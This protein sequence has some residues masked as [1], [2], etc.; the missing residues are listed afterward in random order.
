M[1]GRLKCA[2]TEE[3]R[4]VLSQEMRN[5]WRDNPEFRQRMSEESSAR[6]KEERWKD[7]TF[8]E[9]MAGVNQARWANPIW[10]KNMIQAF[11]LRRAS[12]SFREAHQRSLK[13][14]WTPQRRRRQA[15][16]LQRARPRFQERQ[17]RSA[18]KLMQKRWLDPAY[19]EKMRPHV[20]KWTSEEKIVRGWLVYLGA[21]QMGS[22][23]RVG[24][25]PH[26][27]L[28]TGGSGF[29]TRPAYR[30]DPCPAAHV[31]VPG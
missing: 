15:R 9:L 23:N 18:R 16:A 4:G 28:P 7:P 29:S 5:R 1:G 26:R 27:W 30:L 14:S 19:R 21:Y 22:P 8:R 12:S 2:V 31:E 20:S 11:R 6:L 17:R 10:R 13:A 25:L 24:F 3:R